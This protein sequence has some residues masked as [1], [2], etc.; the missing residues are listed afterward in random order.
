M[1]SI[2]EDQRRSR[3]NIESLAKTPEAKALIT[4]YI[5]KADEQESRLEQ[6]E[7]DKKSLAGEKER[8]EREL[9]TEI[10]NFEAN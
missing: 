5:S 10:R 3:E 6:I 2:S 8:L 1:R 4:R 9:A 7:K